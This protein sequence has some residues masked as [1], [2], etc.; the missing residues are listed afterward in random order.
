MMRVGC[1]FPLCPFYLVE[2]IV[3]DFLVVG[4]Y[5]YEHHN[6]GRDLSLD[7]RQP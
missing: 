3:P 4:Y 2:A 5:V 6:N 1:A 7:N